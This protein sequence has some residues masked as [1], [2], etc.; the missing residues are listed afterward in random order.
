MK[1]ECAWCK[2]FLKE[3]EPMFDNRVSHGICLLCS[4]KIKEE[5]HERKN[6]ARFY[7]VHPKTSRDNQ[8]PTGEN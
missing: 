7:G 1:V 5:I 4:K 6:H 3:I 2:C 8:T